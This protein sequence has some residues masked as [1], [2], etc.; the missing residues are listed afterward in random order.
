MSALLDLLLR[1]T[2]DGI[3]DVDLV[4]QEEIHN[5]RF[6]HLFGFDDDASDDYPRRWRKLVHPAEV[7]STERLIQDHLV[8]DWPFVTTLRMRHRTGGYRNIMLRGAAERD[9]AG[10]PRRMVLVFSDISERIELETRNAERLLQVEKLSAI[11]QLSAGVAHEIN[12]PMQYIGD[13]LHF[14][15]TAVA[16]L[17]RY[18]A[19]LKALLEAER[20]DADE[21]ALAAALAEAAEEADIDYV[22]AELP[23]A[24]ERSLDGIARVTAIVRALK[25]FAHPGS[26]DMAPV[27]V[28]GLVENSVA[29]AIN[30]W[31][32]VAN[33]DVSIDPELPEVVCAGGELGQVLLNLIVNASHAVAERVGTSGEK[34]RISIQARR[35]GTDARLSV[36]DTGAGM[37]E[38]VRSRVF[39]PFFTTKP[40]GKGT[41]QGLALAHASVV[42]RHGGSIDFETAVGVGTT[43]VVRIPIAGPPGTKV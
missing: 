43:F 41:G 28:A 7:E 30:E 33:V 32:Y 21:G 6:A 26:D 8:A 40:V 29:L 16:D 10:E 12:T 23:R 2:Q 37:P 1:A 25:T 4:T 3:V 34:G 31:K 9:G 35:D 19:R 38:S 20:S 22:T 36:R 11:G 24:I 39:E 18:G 17:L 5:P 13:N 15:R 27:N 42:K 14:A